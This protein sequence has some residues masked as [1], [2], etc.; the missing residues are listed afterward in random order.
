LQLCVCGGAEELV[1]G[2]A[3]NSDSATMR[4]PE[5]CA[6]ADDVFG[7]WLQVFGVDGS[8]LPFERK[9][10]EKAMRVKSQDAV[11]GGMSWGDA[12][13]SG[14]DSL[15]LPG[16]GTNGAIT[17]QLRPQNAT[18]LSPIMYLW[19]LKPR[20]SPPFFTTVVVPSP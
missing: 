8:V 6:S 12:P 16:V 11:P 10:R 9:A 19:P 3:T 20:L 14:G 15:Q 5:H 13:R 17:L 1:N 2:P 4:V 7:T 18:I